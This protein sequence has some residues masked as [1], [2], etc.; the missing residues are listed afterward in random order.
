MG[1]R[2][3][4]SSLR[5][6]RWERLFPCLQLCLFLA[7]AG[8]TAAIAGPAV[9]Q[10]PNTAEAPVIAP[11]D[12]KGDPRVN[13]PLAFGVAFTDIDAHDAHL[14][15]WNWGDGSQAPAGVH[16]K[17]GAGSIVGRHVYRKPGH[18]TVRLSV[19]DSGGKRASVTRELVV[20]E[21]ATGVLAISRRARS[22]TAALD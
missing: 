15:R 20:H 21:A 3:Q 6:A 16:C 14:A 9:A 2:T 22:S 17:N 12:V 1:T 13:N 18:Y 10:P 19:L 8:G 7:P 11:I 4:A 5:Y